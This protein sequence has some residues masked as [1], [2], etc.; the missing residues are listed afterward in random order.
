MIHSRPEPFSI[1]EMKELLIKQW[2][3][4]PGQRQPFLTNKT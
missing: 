4:M 3:K 2:Q 1:E